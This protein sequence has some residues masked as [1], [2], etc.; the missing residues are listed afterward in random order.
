M[1][2][3]IVFVQQ[4]LNLLLNRKIINIVYLLTP[5]ALDRGDPLLQPPE[6]SIRDGLGPS[7]AIPPGLPRRGASGHSGRSPTSV[8]EGVQGDAVRPVGRPV[9]GA[10]GCWALFGLR[11]LPT[12]VA[13]IE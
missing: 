7:L 13:G 8:D 5:V 6:A 4:K 1:T 11:A 2:D 12:E 9:P 3:H 10:R